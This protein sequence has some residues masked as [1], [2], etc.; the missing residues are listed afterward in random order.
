MRSRSLRWAGSGGLVL[1]PDE[2]DDCCY[3]ATSSHSDPVRGVVLIRPDHL[4]TY[5]SDFVRVHIVVLSGI[6]LSDVSP[7]TGL[8]HR[9]AEF[10]ISGSS[11]REVVHRHANVLDAFPMALQEIFINIRWSG[12]WLNPLITD[13]A[14]PLKANLERQ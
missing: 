14:H 12:W 10:F 2:W 8:P 11:F 4:S 6:G 9:K 7:C 1:N 13:G 5:A 3:Q